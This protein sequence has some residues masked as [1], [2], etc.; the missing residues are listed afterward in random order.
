MLNL[1]NNTTISIK[2]TPRANWQ[3]GILI[4]PAP[5]SEAPA[6]GLPGPKT[7]D[8]QLVETA[9]EGSD[10][11]EQR[12]LLSL[13]SEKGLSSDTLRQAGGS[14]ARWLA[15]YKVIDA[16]VAIDLL[17][18][19]DIEGSV[20]AFCEGL[21]LGSFQFITWKP[22]ASVS[23]IITVHL[24]VPGE[25]V[26]LRTKIARISAVANAVNLARAW[27]H[28]PPNVINPETLAQR[29]GELAADT[30]LACTVLS[31]Q[32]LETLGAGAI[33]GV[34]QGSKTGSRLI[35]LA[36]KG[37]GKQAD[38]PPVVI[39]GKAITFDTGGYT[40]KAKAGMSTMKYDKSGGM[41]VIGVMAAVAALNLAVP[42]IGLVPAAENMISADAYR[43]NDI[44]T[45]LSGQ[46]VEIVSADA[47]GRM[48]LADALTY[49][50]RI[51]QP[52]SLIDIA[53]LTG[54]VVTALGRVRA[55]LMSNDDTLAQALFAAGARTQERLWRLPLD[56][57]YFELI[58][59]DDSDFKNSSLIVE[60]SPIVGGTFLK[61]FVNEGVPWAHIDIAGAGKA[62]KNLPYTPK[63]YTGFGVR[64]LLDYLQ[65]LEG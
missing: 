12:V 60:A 13:G 11:T 22:S 47:E 39:V 6:P 49:A 1:Y 31:H 8:I 59:G 50:Q 2:I 15:K 44:I 4:V 42:V 28:E 64:L 24:L 27:A 58:K 54:G 32:E 33:V 23:P 3:P 18:Q 57:E 40:I 53:T 26:S 46:T 38:Q 7:G 62:L 16:A 14:L 65:T 10:T 5:A 21:I 30:G 9:V 55:G 51:Y 45:T 20:Q 63:G 29:A 61:Q 34:G 48:I 43:P 36:H 56:E 37:H 35:I 19:L 17:D 52:R 41:A 25:G